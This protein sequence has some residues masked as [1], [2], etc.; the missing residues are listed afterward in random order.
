MDFKF[1]VP[2]RFFKFHYLSK[3]IVK[4]C[5]TKNKLEMPDNSWPNIN[6]RNQ[7]LRKIGML[8]LICHSKF[9]LPQWEYLEDMPFTDTLRNRSMEGFQLPNDLLL[10][11]LICQ[12]SK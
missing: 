11:F 2:A 6:E 3:I 4:R 9:N 8:E 5:P 1:K 7:R 10:S 12:K